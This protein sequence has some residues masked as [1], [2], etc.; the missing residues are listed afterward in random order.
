MVNGHSLV[1]GLVAVAVGGHE[2][3]GEPAGV[4]R[5]QLRDVAGEAAVGEVA[6]A[7]VQLVEQ[8]LDRERSMMP[9]PAAWC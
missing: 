6:V 1:A 7:G 3:D 8:P 9:G 4:D 5:R 2:R